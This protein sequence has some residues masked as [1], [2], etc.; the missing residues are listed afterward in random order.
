[1]RKLTFFIACL[2]MI[3]VGLVNA[4]SKSV[5]GKVLS[6]EDGQ[7]VIG[8]SVV[9]KG[10]TDGTITDVNGS[11]TLTVPSAS[12]ILWFSYVGMKTIELQATNNM[13]VRLESDTKI[14]DELVVTAL[15]MK[16]ERKALGYAVQDV[17]A[18]E[19]T[20]AGSNSLSSALQGKLSGVEIKPSSGMPGASSQIIIRGARSF[21]GNNSPLYV[22]DGMP[23]SSTA[24][25]GTGN[26]V[27]GTDNATRSVDIDPNDIESVNVLKGQAAAALYGIRASNGVIVITTKSGKGAKTTK[28]IISV[29][30]SLSGDRVSRLPEIQTTWAQGTPNSAWTSTSPATTAK[31]LFNPNG[32]T[33]WGPRISDLPKDPTYGGET[34][35]TYTGTTNTVAQPGKYY[36]PQ[37]KIGGLDPWATP[38]SY[39]NIS[40]F[41]G[42]GITLNNSL[43]ISQATD[44]SNFSVGFG[45]TNQTGI[46]EGTSMNRIN[47]K[48]LAETKLSNT[49]KTGF[50][51]NYTQ[52]Y[53]EK[54]PG[55][56][57]G[58]VATVYSAPSNYDLK[59]LPYAS[60]TDP[61]TQILYRATNFNNPYWAIANNKFNEK[62]NRFFGNAYV[63]YSPKIGTDKSLT[64]KYQAGADSYTTH[65]E[66]IHEYKSKNT[67][68]SVI[69]KGVT[70]T[71]YNSLLTANYDMTLL[72]EIK[73]N[74]IAGNEINHEVYKS[75]WEQGQNFNF[76]GWPHI[77]NATIKDASESKSQYRT[78]G[79]FGNLM[80]SYKDM[81]YLNASLRSDVVSSMPRGNRAFTYP[82]ISLGFIA[83]ELE[84][85][86]NNDILSFAKIRASYA[87][88]GQA[89]SYTPNYYSTPSYSG[90]FWT[91]APIVYPINSVVSYTPN[92][93]MYDPNL[94]PQNTKGYE[95]GGDFKFLDNLFG[96]EYTYSRQNV[97]D[98]IFSVPLAGSTG[99]SSL[100]MNGGAIHTNTHELLI[101][102][103]PIRK[104]N[105]DWVVNI[106]FT[107][108]DNYVDELA[109]GVESIFL[110]GFVTPQVR[111][112]IGEK[113]PVIYGSQ[114]KR[115]AQGRILVNETTTSPYY[116]MPM[117]GS[118][119][120]IGKVAPDFIMGASTTLRVKSIT[121][122]ATFDWKNGG[123]MYHGTNG[124]LTYTYG[125]AKSTDDRETPFTY[126]GY[127]AD[128][129]PNNIQRGGVNDPAAYYN[130]NANT[131]GSIDEAFVFNNSYLK[132][133]EL[134]LS[135]SLPK[136]KSLS[137]TI[138]GFARNFL[139]WTNLPNFDPEA[140][141]GN[142][143]MGGAFE[144]F[145]TPQSSS[146][147]MGLNV[148]F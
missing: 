106:N 96:I 76:G 53:I 140:T 90:G 93:V 10:T 43:N 28:P 69:N 24:D 19:L 91:G 107:K 25:Y 23:I 62:T 31:Y 18:E 117:I 111:A 108:M 89:G 64:L 134:S 147:G 36:V 9:V 3:G 98:Q 49:W 45:N 33:N 104:K 51:A 126:P 109:P 144:R 60:P 1:M 84:A 48:A 133:R 86:K 58:L 136:M 74:V 29:N 46:I 128:G 143:N 47:A 146:V 71:V 66:D 101:S 82:S 148:V 12:S 70:T 20:R 35:N 114:Y 129:T 131:L 78:I 63:E 139:L 17:K 138:S 5:S 52:T 135:Y 32:S 2:F 141:Q 132:M 27:T 80:A 121:L 50:S 94:K 38:Q 113:F 11:F 116:G 39:D 97:T 145:T 77:N 57:D 4:Q 79:F 105:I 40:T 54:A 16:R 13:V 120:V 7:P 61:Y 92:N 65:N 21:T 119:G 137:V 127:K 87:E 26:G 123:Q 37:R 95:L 102:I 130:L 8:A 15:G 142:T 34:V 68:G 55:A 59:G 124:L 41:F 81:L 88:V 100:V 122:S 6:A 72:D 112:G 73:I 30:T 14:M 125:L 83:T 67:L 110:G 115:D 22:I 99:A 56:N 118:P 85:L 75:Y 42:T 44:K 103:N